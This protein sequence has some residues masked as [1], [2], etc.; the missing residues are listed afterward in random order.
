[1]EYRFGMSVTSIY[2]FGDVENMVA[3]AESRSALFGE[4]EFR[5][6]LFERID[7]MLPAR[8]S[9]L[10][11]DVFDTL[12][13]RDGSAELTRFIEIGSLM[14][15]FVDGRLGLRENAGT[16]QALSKRDIDAFIARHMGTKA[17]YRARERIRG[18][19]EGSLTEIHSVA[20]RLLTGDKNSRDELIEVELNYEATKVSPNTLL[21]DYV[22]HHRNRGGKAI[23]LSDMYM[24]GVQIESLLS[25]VGVDL[26]LFDL[27][28]SSADTRLTKG[29]G[30][31][32]VE[33]EKKLGVPAGRFLHI[34]DSLTGDFQ[35]PRRNG[36]LALHLPISENE[37]KLRRENH[38]LS[39]A[40]L[41]DRFSL[42]VDVAAPH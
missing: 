40:M 34:G 12:I 37:M 9:V 13:L 18:Y 11:L 5:K 39:V 26:T 6:L 27:V 42:E 31:V 25:K 20:S 32:F 30:A 28:S 15:R 17:T 10:S 36:W 24:H 2:R 38:F 23:L 4:A 29:S 1:M 41:K 3:K 14:A 21:V 35:Q 7:S 8:D 19:G 16:E 22:Q 33:I